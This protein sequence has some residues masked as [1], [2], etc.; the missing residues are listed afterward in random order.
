MQL[1]VMGIAIWLSFIALIAP[2]VLWEYKY[3]LRLLAIVY[4]LSIDNTSIFCYY[5]RV[6]NNK[7]NIIK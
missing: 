7:I 5:M 3:R 2:F 4:H 6:G 1:S